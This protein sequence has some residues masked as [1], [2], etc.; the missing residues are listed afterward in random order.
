MK[1]YL[2]SGQV[3][4]LNDVHTIVI[5]NTSFGI[6]RFYDKEVD[7]KYLSKLNVFRLCQDHQDK[8]INFY[9]DACSAF[10]TLGSN[11]SAI[12]YQEEE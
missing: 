2:K 7:N 1:L 4:A 5:N 6:G 9:Y 8:N 10:E 12:D 3:V 11:V